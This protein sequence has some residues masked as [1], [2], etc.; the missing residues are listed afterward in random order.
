M[1]N[2]KCVTVGGKENL[3]V[4]FKMIKIRHDKGRPPE[5]LDDS[6]EKGD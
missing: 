6:E 4:P 5:D 1:E 2:G 3:W